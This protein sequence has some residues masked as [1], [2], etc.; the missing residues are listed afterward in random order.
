MT[1][2][3]KHRKLILIVAFAMLIALTVLLFW[4][5]EAPRNKVNF[6]AYEPTFL[7]SGTIINSRTLYLWNGEINYPEYLLNLNK[8]DITIQEARADVSRRPCM[9][10]SNELCRQY[11]TPG[12][13]AYITDTVTFTHST[14]KT[15]SFTKNGTFIWISLD[16]REPTM[17]DN[18]TDWNKVIDSFR[19]VNLTNVR[20][21]RVHAGP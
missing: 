16:G 10:T 4:R 15:I 13:Q 21:K 7:P 20:A 18:A 11:K 14:R 2:S 8:A 6:Q 1:I 12:H 3:H 19:P 5:H 9:G 17:V